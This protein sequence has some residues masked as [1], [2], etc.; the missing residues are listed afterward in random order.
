MVD[1]L[2]NRD[3]DDDDDSPTAIVTELVLSGIHLPV[4]SD[5]GLTTVLA[6]VLCQERYSSLTK[7]HYFAIV[8]LA[9]QL[10]K[11]YN[12]LLPALHTNRTITDIKIPR[13]CRRVGRCCTW[14]FPLR[15]NAKHAAAA[16]A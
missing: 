8:V 3:D 14:K 7:T 6:A 4:P 1:F 10:K 13:A 2:D 5:G 12:F 11:P 15:F 16:T 9:L